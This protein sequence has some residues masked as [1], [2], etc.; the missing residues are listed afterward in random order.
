MRENPWANVGR[1]LAGHIV[2]R[3]AKDGS[4]YDQVPIIRI[5][6][7]QM[8]D[9]NEVYGVHLRDGRRSYHANGYLVMVNYPEVSFF[10]YRSTRK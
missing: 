5:H 10:E 9:V 4:R 8:P 7:H 1:L 6:S 2:Y 3:L